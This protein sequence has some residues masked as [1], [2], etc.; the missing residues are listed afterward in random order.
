MKKVYL[1]AATAGFSL[2]TYH[3]Q[4]E[5]FPDLRPYL[6]DPVRQFSDQWFPARYSSS[7]GANQTVQSYI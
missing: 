1:F 3:H 4:P 2:A 5:I 7:E 6:P